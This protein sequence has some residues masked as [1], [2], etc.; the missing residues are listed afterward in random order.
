MARRIALISDHA[1]P[2]AA[3][4]GAACVAQAARELGTRGHELD[5]SETFYRAGPAQLH[6]VRCGF[7]K[8]AFQ[9]LPRRSASQTLGIASGERQRVNVGRLVPRKGIDGATRGLGCLRRAHGIDAT[10]LVVGGL[11]S[12]IQVGE[13]GFLVSP[14]RS[15][16][17]RRALRAP[18]HVAVTLADAPARR[19]AGR[20]RAV[21][22]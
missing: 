16:D 4:G 6:V 11:T 21:A 7:G 3:L 5:V 20:A 14:G 12:T 13:T 22:S 8:D 10:P 9:P 18:E 15:R 1:S 2:L 19:E 17:P